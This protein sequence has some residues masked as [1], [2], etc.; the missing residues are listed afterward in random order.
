MVNLEFT[1]AD[2]LG[3]EALACLDLYFAELAARFPGG[4]DRQA[5]G[6]SAVEDFAAPTGC[7]LLARLEGRPVGCGA[8]RGLSP[9]VGEI[10]RMWV[11]PEVRGFG[12]ARQ[13]LQQLELFAA[14]QGWRLVRL[15]TNASLHEAI[16]LYLRSGYRE[17]ARFN[18]NPYAQRWFEKSLP[19]GASSPDC[20]FGI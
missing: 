17:I 2:P 1:P 16:S 9:G 12:V 7:L 6:A 14:K 8:I 18:D 20:R 3:S 13:L 11:S 10:K 4:F 19:L 15:D 5:G